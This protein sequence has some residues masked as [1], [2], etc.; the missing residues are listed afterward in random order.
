M[1]AVWATA[2][3]LMSATPGS[4]LPGGFSIQGHL[5][6]YTVFGL[7][8]YR[9]LRLNC[10]RGV[11]LAIAIAIASAYGVTDEFHQSFV[12]LR[13]PDPADWMLDT[14]GATFGASIALAAEVLG[15]RLRAKK[16]DQ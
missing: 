9:A 5:F 11:A 12:P 16:A 4:S 1:V 8:L 10:G 6:E 15:E 7:L 3:F 13:T 2:I 14:L